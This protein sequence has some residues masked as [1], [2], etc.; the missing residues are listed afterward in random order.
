MG[1]N[2]G[3]SIFKAFSG[4]IHFDKK[5]RNYQHKVLGDCPDMD[6][7]DSFATLDESPGEWDDSQEEYLNDA[8]VWVHTRSDSGAVIIPNHWKS[9]DNA[10]CTKQNA[11][12]SKLGN[13]PCGDLRCGGT[14]VVERA[15]MALVVAEQNIFK[16][17]EWS[18]DMMIRCTN[19]YCLVQNPPRRLPGTYHCTDTYNCKA[20][21]SVSNEAAKEADE[22]MEERAEFERFAGRIRR[23]SVHLLESGAAARRR[24]PDKPAQFG[25]HAAAH[26]STPSFAT[27][28]TAPTIVAFPRRNKPVASPGPRARTRPTEIVVDVWANRQSSHS[29]D[30]GESSS[31]SSPTDLD[32]FGFYLHVGGSTP[33]LLNDSKMTVPAVLPLNVKPRPRNVTEGYRRSRLV[34]HF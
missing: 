14:F 11:M 19:E 16:Y 24:R 13:Y 1:K 27:C 6:F 32:D 18:E 15:D 23:D 22:Q 7:Q 20:K 21:Y 3:S 10:A 29:T 25:M 4:R 8:R 30:T 34:S 31:S 17:G 2:T 9:C 28:A 33:L 12:R 5:K 26:A